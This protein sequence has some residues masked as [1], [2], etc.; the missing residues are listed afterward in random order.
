MQTRKRPGRRE[1]SRARSLSAA[2]KQGRTLKKGGRNRKKG[3]RQRR[4]SPEG[5]H[6]LFLPLLTVWFLAILVLAGILYWGGP[7]KKSGTGNREDLR[8]TSPHKGQVASGTRKET[9]P[10]PNR[11][12]EKV[13]EKVPG[14]AGTTPAPGHQT[15]G[16]KDARQTAPQAVSAEAHK[17][18]PASGRPVIEPPPQFSSRDL[19]ADEPREA[20]HEQLARANLQA[21]APKPAPQPLPPP[22][23]LA[24]PVARVAIVIDDLGMNLDM[25]RKLLEVPL[26]LTFS[27]LPGQPHS[28]EIAE[29]A[30]S[31]H[32]EVLLH[33]PM[34]PLGF[35]KTNP[36]FGALLTSMSAEKIRKI[37]GE[38]IDSIPYSSGVNNHMGSRFT[39][40]AADM[41]IVMAELQRRKLYF[42]D[43]CTSAKSTG[44]SI[45]REFR[46]PS[47]KRDIFLDHIATREFVYSQIDQLIRKARIEGSAL[48]IGHPYGITL[49]VLLKTAER[50]KNENIAVVPAGELM[51]PVHEAGKKD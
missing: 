20:A 25:A 44:I 15:P 8:A 1:T 46:V 34:E 18:Q 51:P 3:A 28:R 30:H 14:E 49:N 35:P 22:P 26:Q 24:P 48:A 33:L 45:A 17:T 40:N 2:G 12:T 16:V 50:F 7:P 37:V 11:Q 42:L 21:V 43:S 10:A 36:G 9:S 38:D 5:S 47:R 19:P 41:K 27:V 23:S 13:A 32:H 4:V 31:N 6:S 39:E 29:M